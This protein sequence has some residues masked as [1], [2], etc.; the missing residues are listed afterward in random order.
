M[1]S[2]TSQCLKD[3][4]AVVAAL[5]AAAVLLG[6]PAGA[7]AASPVLEFVVPGHSLPIGFTTESGSVL[8]Q[9]AEF[10]PLVHCEASHGEGEITGPRST[11][12]NYTFTGCK[13]EHGA[14]AKCKSTGA[15]EEEIK[16]GPIYADLVY[17]NQAKHEVAML[18]VP[19]GGTYIAFECGGKPAEGRGPFLAP[20]APINTEANIFTAT[21]SQLESMQTPDEYEGTNGE[22]LKAIPMGEHDGKA[23][24]TTGVQAAFT[25]NPN[26]S[27]YIK[28]VSAEEVEAKQHEEEAKQREQRQHEEEAAAAR[29]HQEEATATKKH[30]E[31]EAAKKKA[32]EEAAAK[33]HAEEVKK[34][35]EEAKSKSKQPT[36]AQLL[37]EALKQCKKDKPKS[38]R[39]QCEKAANRKYGAKTKKKR[40]KK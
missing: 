3:H 32:E 18:L 6:V 37:A 10:E 20:V 36:R 16:T 1:K 24:V 4:R 2:R 27:G 12:S 5:I 29:K 34:Q 40:H 26:V 28:A 21:L 23:F 25:I 17:I 14:N 30:Q 11:V 8:A 33:K 9:M 13:T 15:N 38:K 19:G 31:E 22:K 39:M 35:E 7:S